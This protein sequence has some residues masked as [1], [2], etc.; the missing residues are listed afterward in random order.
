MLLLP[1]GLGPPARVALAA[2]LAALG[3]VTI[4]FFGPGRA[5]RRALREPEPPVL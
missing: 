2:G 5:L 3:L 1:V 4:F